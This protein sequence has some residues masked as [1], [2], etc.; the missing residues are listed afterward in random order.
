MESSIPSFRAPASTSSTDIFI[1]GTHLH[2]IICVSFI[3]RTVAGISSNSTAI[4]FSSLVSANDVRVFVKVR[5]TVNNTKTNFLTI[6]PP[7]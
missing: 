5:T 6:F 2:P 3:I 7:I 4:I 1:K